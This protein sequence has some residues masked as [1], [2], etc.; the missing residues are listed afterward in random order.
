MSSSAVIELVPSIANC[1][2]VVRGFLCT[3]STKAVSFRASRTP[4]EASLRHIIYD[5]LRLGY[6]KVKKSTLATLGVDLIDQG[7]KGNLNKS[8][9]HII[10]MSVEVKRFA[11]AHIVQLAVSSFP[12][13]DTIEEVIDLFDASFEKVSIVFAECL[14]ADFEVLFHGLSMSFWLGFVNNYLFI[15]S[16]WIASTLVA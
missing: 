9:L 13:I 2:T 10:W 15:A 14:V 7:V 8:F 12:I 11:V 6:S 3:D 1:T 4:K 5:A 16:W